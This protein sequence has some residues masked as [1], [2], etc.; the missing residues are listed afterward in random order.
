MSGAATIPRSSSL[1]ISS[2]LRGMLRS[3]FILTL[4]AG[5]AFVNAGAD[6][7]AQ[8]LSKEE[9]ARLAA[10]DEG[11]TPA[12][13]IA[14]PF[15]DA[16]EGDGLAAHWQVLNEDR[17]R[18]VAERGML[19]AITSGGRDGFDNADARNIYQLQ[20]AMPDGDFDISLG[21]R[22]DAKTGFDEVWLGL[23]ESDEN[24]VAAHLYVHTKGCGPA[25]YISTVANQPLNPE[26]P[27]V[28]SAMSVNLFDGPAARNIC[29]KTGRAYGDRVLA[30][31]YEKGFVLTLS[32]RGLRYQAKVTLDLPAGEGEA[33]GGVQ[34]FSG[35]RVA[36]MAGFGSPAFMVG[37]GKKAKGGE[38]LA[39]F[40]RFSIKRPGQ[41]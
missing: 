15:E 17:D 29:N 3:S 16:F 23:R 20:G 36:R 31:L 34:E 18:Y 14:L 19:L 8:M 39:E 4:L 5:V 32:R 30:D 7:R 2:P 13:A 27:A 22:L 24:F 26:E 33:V 35:G 1:A 25:L 41:Q 28:P 37:Q 11:K 9:Q 12:T 38:T 40:D 21:G 10:A 6:A